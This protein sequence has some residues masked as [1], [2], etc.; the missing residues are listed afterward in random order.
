MGQKDL[1]GRLARWSLKLQAFDFPIEHRK[2][3]LNVVPDALSRVH[4]DELQKTGAE[5]LDLH[6]NL[7]STAFQSPDYVKLVQAVEQ[8][9]GKNKDLQTSEG[10]VYK[11]MGLCLNDAVDEGRV[12]KLWVPTELRPDFYY[13]PGMAVDVQKIVKEFEVCKI[14]K[15]A[16]KSDQPPMGEQR[17]RESAGQ[18]LFIDFMGPYPRTKGWS[19]YR[20]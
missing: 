20:R 17:I 2:G 11:R 15:T 5:E 16:N 18:R 12:W 13:W 9:L 19:G 14:T 6:I 1:S 7:D 4:M 3:S 8:Q 10:Y